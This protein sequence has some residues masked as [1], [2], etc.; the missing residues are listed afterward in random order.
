MHELRVTEAG[1]YS[2]SVF[3]YSV[4]IFVMY[5]TLLPTAMY[6]N[7]VPNIL[8]ARPLYEDLFNPSF[9]GRIRGTTPASTSTEVRITGQCLMYSMS[10][11]YGVQVAA[12]TVL[13]PSTAIKYPLPRWYL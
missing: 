6:S 3:R 7:N 9:C 10:D 2:V 11:T 13:R 8:H 12:I 4:E 1:G 5:S